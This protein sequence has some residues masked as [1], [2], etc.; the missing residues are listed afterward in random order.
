MTVIQKGVCWFPEESLR[1]DPSFKI[2]WYVVFAD[3]R[4]LPSSICGWSRLPWSWPH[5][6]AGSS[7]GWQG[8]LRD[9]P[10]FCSASLATP[11]K[12]KTYLLIILQK[13]KNTQKQTKR[14]LRYD[15][16]GLPLAV[17]ERVRTEWLGWAGLCART[18]WAQQR[19]M[20]LSH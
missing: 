5:P 8:G 17:T 13:N 11:E 10:A 16:V 7:E 20:N 2:S 12:E 19:L 9:P 4:H 1:A 6:Q 18:R 14:P 3:P 15:P